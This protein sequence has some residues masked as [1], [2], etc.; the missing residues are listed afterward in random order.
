M[1]AVDMGTP[2]TLMLAMVIVGGEG[3]DLDVN[4]KLGRECWDGEKRRDEWR[5]FIGGGGRSCD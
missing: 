4:F 3:E 2:W 5:S 1:V